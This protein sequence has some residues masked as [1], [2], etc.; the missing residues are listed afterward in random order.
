MLNTMYKH[1]CISNTVP[2]SN[3]VCRYSP[4]DVVWTSFQYCTF[5]SYYNKII[6]IMVYTT[7]YDFVDY[8]NRYTFVYC[9]CASICILYYT[10]VRH[11]IILFVINFSNSILFFF[12]RKNNLCMFCNYRNNPTNGYTLYSWCD[13][14]L[15][16]K[17]I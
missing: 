8:N 7:K 13:V 15:F 12:L 2:D 9:V 4:T 6:I 3:W 17:Y 1:Y 11:P 14:Y 10:C 5:A 16:F